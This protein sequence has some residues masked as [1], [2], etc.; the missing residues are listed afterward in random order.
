MSSFMEELPTYMEDRVLEAINKIPLEEQYLLIIVLFLKFVFCY[1]VELT[2]SF[3]FL[4]FASLYKTQGKMN[5]YLID[6]IMKSLTF[7]EN[8]LTFIENIINTRP[9]VTEIERYVAFEDYLLLLEAKLYVLLA[10][11]TCCHGEIFGK[12]YLT[13]DEHGNYTFDEKKLIELLSPDIPAE[14]MNNLMEK[15][16]CSSKEDCIDKMIHD[17]NSSPEVVSGLKK[18][19]EKQNQET[20]RIAGQ[21]VKIKEGVTTYLRNDP[22]T[23]INLSN[24]IVYIFNKSDQYNCLVYAGGEW[25]IGHPDDTYNIDVS[26]GKY[27]DREHQKFFFYDKGLF[28]YIIFENKDVKKNV[29]PM[30]CFRVT[31]KESALPIVLPK[32]AFDLSNTETY[33]EN[34]VIKNAFDDVK[35]VIQNI[36]TGQQNGD[37][38]FEK[39]LNA[40]PEKEYRTKERFFEMLKLI[41]RAQDNEPRKEEYHNDNDQII[42]YSLDIVAPPILESCEV[43]I[44]YVRDSIIY[45]LGRFVD[46]TPAFGDWL[47]RNWNNIINEMNELL[48]RIRTTNQPEVNHENTVFENRMT[49]YN[50]NNNIIPP[51]TQGQIGLILTQPPTRPRAPSRTQGTR[52]NTPQFEQTNAQEQQEATREDG[53]E[54]VDNMNQRAEQR[55]N[56][57]LYNQTNTRNQP[58]QLYNDL[59]I[60]RSASQDDIKR[61]FRTLARRWHPDKN[62]YNVDDATARFQQISL[63]Y[64]VLSDPVKRARYD[65]NGSIGGKTI[66]HRKGR[67]KGTKY[68]KTNKKYKKKLPR[69]TIKKHQKKSSRKRKTRRIN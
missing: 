45:L 19:A 4:T 29:I 39:Y 9:D 66:K 49:N 21:K 50:E 67:R 34:P 22:T 15:Y 33:T 64:T 56:E 60:E 8:N 63:A 54:F 12:Q 26:T 44:L 46:D 69:K 61:A 37:T 1:G 5:Q 13:R 25:H 27:V 62:P 24:R 38:N 57:R 41:F 32:D 43:G 40:V 47:F 35:K 31:I 36:F 53:Q 20:G 17:V 10:N 55:H 14:L 52:P 59:G 42:P 11:L 28:K 68:I 51:V 7:L 2:T 18:I 30:E 23:S 58:N 48:A 65:Y 3:I 6:T 16:E